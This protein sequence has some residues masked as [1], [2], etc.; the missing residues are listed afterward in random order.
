M[1]EKAVCDENSCQLK[2][3][4]NPPLSVPE[5]TRIPHIIS[6]YIRIVRSEQ[7]SNIYQC[8]ICPNYKV[9]YIYRLELILL[10]KLF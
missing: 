1:P 2:K 7:N 6:S 3:T 5:K 8:L 9:G 4:Q 10:F